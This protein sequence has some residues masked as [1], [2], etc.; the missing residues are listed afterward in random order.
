MGTKL[1]FSVIMD[2]E[3]FGA[4][5]RREYLSVLFCALALTKCFPESVVDRDFPRKF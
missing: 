4:D 3:P 5:R 1:P 2:P